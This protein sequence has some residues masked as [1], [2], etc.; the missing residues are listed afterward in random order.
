MAWGWCLGRWINAFLLGLYSNRT[1]GLPLELVRGI[2]GAP[3]HLYFEMRNCP[4]S[5]TV[6]GI[7]YCPGPGNLLFARA[8]IVA[9]PNFVPT[10]VR[11][12]AIS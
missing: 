8:G 10:E 4:L 11:F 6:V 9:F 5:V 3:D 7:L 2:L 12:D 1:V